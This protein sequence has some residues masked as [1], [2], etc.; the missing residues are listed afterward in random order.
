MRAPVWT[1]RYES[2]TRPLRVD[3]L[4][5]SIR[6]PFPPS[7]PNPGR[8]CPDT[9]RAGEAC[10][11]QAH[12]HKPDLLPPTTITTPYGPNHH[13]HNC[14]PAPYPPNSMTA[15]IRSSSDAPLLRSKK[16]TGSAYA[17]GLL[18]IEDEAWRVARKEREVRGE[19]GGNG[20]GS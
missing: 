16:W 11:R 18:A 14:N 19:Q 13:N 7:L 5:I 15:R 6:T 8:T 1:T 12:S 9:T 10:A 20:E 2:S 17:S 3:H 4:V